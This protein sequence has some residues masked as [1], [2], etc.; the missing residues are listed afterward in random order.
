MGGAALALGIIGL[1]LGGIP[2][3][4]TIPALIFGILAWIL[5]GK[6]A[7]VLRASEN[8][9][10]IGVAITGKVLGI[11]GTIQGLIMLVV[12]GL[13]LYPAIS[14]AQTKASSN[15]MAMRGRSLYQ[16]VIMANVERE[17]SGLGSVWPRSGDKLGDDADDIGGRNF[18]S[19]TKYFET[20][21]DVPN[22]GT[23]DHHSYVGDLDLSVLAGD[24]VTKAADGARMLEGKN[25]GWCVLK[26]VT[27]EMDDVVPVLVSANVNVDDLV[28]SGDFDG[29]SPMMVRLGTANGA[30]KDMFGNKCFVVVRKSGAAEVIDAKYGKLYRVYQNMPFSIPRGVTLEYLKP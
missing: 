21:F 7:K 24:G 17:A 23:K 2:V 5:G 22:N 29:R 14:S 28:T 12:F 26:G 25:V 27:D 1:I 15:A 8:K 18:T 11:I 9:A 30:A 16:A 19:A 4:G 20:L 3:W 13:L 6:K 10:G